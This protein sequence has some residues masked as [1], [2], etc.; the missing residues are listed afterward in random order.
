MNSQLLTK[1][2]TSE[3]VKAIESVER[4]YNAIRKA[5][6][7][8]KGEESLFGNDLETVIAASKRIPELE[9]KL[10]EVEK[11]RD[12][13]HKAYQTVKDWAHRLEYKLIALME[14]CEAAAMEQPPGSF[15]D[16]L[17]GMMN[18]LD[19]KNCDMAICHQWKSMAEKLGDFIVHSP[20]CRAGPQKEAMCS[21]CD[22]GLREIVIELNKLQGA[23]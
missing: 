18:D 10:T 11:E 13:N 14:K 4:A 3:L 22:C 15:P 12:E 6:P 2:S 8:L 21:T 20:S 17:V 7:A 5:L 19:V 23:K 16:T 1:E 9:Q